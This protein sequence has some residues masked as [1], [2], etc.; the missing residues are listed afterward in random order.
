MSSDSKEELSITVNVK[1]KE[2]GKEKGKGK[3]K[4]KE[5]EKEKGLTKKGST[6]KG[7][8]LTKKGEGSTKKGGSSYKREGSLKVC[9]SLKKR[10]SSK[11]SGLLIGEGSLS[12][13]QES[14]KQGDE[15]GKVDV[16]GKDVGKVV[17]DDEQKVE[18]M[19]EVGKKRDGGGSENSSQTDHDQGTVY[20]SL[21]FHFTFISLSI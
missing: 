12:K 18:E 8:G 2:K 10:Q 16:M 17:S 5:R 3:G 19:A 14:P 11:G 13:G 4:G 20:F 1:G 21:I 15:G 7:E 9:V 6:T